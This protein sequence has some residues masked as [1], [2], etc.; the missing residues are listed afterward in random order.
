MSLRLSPNSAAFTL[1]LGALAALPSF[2]ID[3]NLPALGAI[4]ASLGVD[5]DGA[6]L[7]M[8]V[9]MISF[10]IGPPLCGPISDRIGRKPVVLGAVALFAVASLGCA[11]ARSLAGLLAWR[12]AQ[13][14]GAGVAMTTALAIISDEFDGTGGRA[15]LSTITSLML[16]VPMIAPAAGT[17]MMTVGS[18]R[19]I[20]GLLAGIG[21]ALL[22]VLW[23]FF[24]ESART[25]YTER[26]S[27]A[28]MLR[29]YAR[30]LTHPVC[31]GYILVNAA[32]FGALFAYVS[33]S[34]LFFIGAVGLSRSEYSMVFAA[35]SVGIMA[36]SFVN[37]WL[38]KRGIAPAY[39][40]G[41]GVALALAAAASL[42]GAIMVGCTWVPGLVG[43]LVLGTMS[44]GLITPNATRCGHAAPADPCR[45]RQRDGGV[46]AGAGW[47]SIECARGLPQ[48]C[49]SRAVDGGVDGLLVGGRSCR[50]CVPCPARRIWTK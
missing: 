26:L 29:D 48:R 42:L 4:G 33:G 3:M 17:A 44:F 22:C 28:A 14:M 19:S 20:Y 38:S 13:G 43:I 46:R 47:I 24:A 11:A 21:F 9:F 36:G 50:P 39:P 30:V 35:T 1:L 41:V 31:R 34:S 18:W 6:G 15:K 45:R 5:A 7:T 23:A 40:L 10:A 32:G 37:G 27:P 49:A 16:F 8:S 2:G 12:V 25:S